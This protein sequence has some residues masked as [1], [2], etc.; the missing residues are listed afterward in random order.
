MTIPRHTSLV[1]EPTFFSTAD[2]V[3][4][5]IYQDNHMTRFFSEGTYV[6]DVVHHRTLQDN[7]RIRF[8]SDRTYMFVHW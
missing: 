4:H 2:V 7:R 6:D 1:E 5:S 3:H 8:T